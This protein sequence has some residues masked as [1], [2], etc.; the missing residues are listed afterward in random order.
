MLKYLLEAIVFSLL[1]SEQVRRNSKIGCFDNG[2]LK[3][4]SISASG[5]KTKFLS[6][7]RG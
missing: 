4:G 2:S 6:L 5:I 3:A 1:S 7:N